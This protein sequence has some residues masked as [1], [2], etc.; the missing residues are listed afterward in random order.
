MIGGDFT[1]GEEQDQDFGSENF[2][3]VFKLNR[4]GDLNQMLLEGSCELQKS[5]KAPDPF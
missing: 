3:Q 1:F 2:F 4:R 5:V